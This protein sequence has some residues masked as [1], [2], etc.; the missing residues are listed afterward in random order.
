M[1]STR[2][3]LVRHGESVAQ[4]EG[5]VGGPRA[6]RGLSEKGRRQVEALRDRWARTGLQADFLLSS[7][8]PRAIETAELLSEALGG[9]VPERVENLCEILP[10]ECDGMTWDDFEEQFRG[11]D[12]RW[13][14][15]TPVAPGGESWVEFQ[16]RVSE[17][18]GAIVERL[19][20]R[21]IVAAV[22]GG[23]VDGSM[24]HFLGLP[25]DAGHVLQ[26]MNASVTEWLYV[27][28]R[29][30]WERGGWRLVRFNDHAHLEDVDLED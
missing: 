20:G 28:P 16:T 18:I 5:I 14:P 30:N 9:L 10:G 21:T 11:G 13:D 6:C 29:D 15:H 26:T 17:T 12:Y 23:I 24:V 27:E 22:H 7:T 25:K 2:L 1:P 4:V 8:L 3:I 19:E